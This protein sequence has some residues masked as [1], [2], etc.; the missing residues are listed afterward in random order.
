V[1]ISLSPVIA[2]RLEIPPH[3]FL[4]P[5]TISIEVAVVPLFGFEDVT[6]NS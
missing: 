5:S 6:T 3:S 2:A 4:R 1:Y